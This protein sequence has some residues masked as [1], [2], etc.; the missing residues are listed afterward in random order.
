MNAISFALKL[1]TFDIS[2]EILRL[3]FSKAFGRYHRGMVDVEANIEALVI[4][5]YV[6]VVCNLIGGRDVTIPLIR[7]PREEVTP[8]E[9]VYRIPKH[10]TDG[11]SI[12]MLKHIVTADVFHPGVDTGNF[13]CGRSGLALEV[14]N[15]MNAQ[16][17][18][19]D[20][21]TTKLQLIGD[22]VV[23][24]RRQTLMSDYSHLM[25]VVEYDRNMSDI[26]PRVIPVF[27]EMCLLATKA[28][29]YTQM[30]V[31]I[32]QGVLQG[33]RELGVIADEVR[34]YADAHEMFRQQMKEIYQKSLFFNDEVKT[35][36]HVNLLM[37]GMA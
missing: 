22:N 4:R 27:S 15:V 10:L 20:V 13:Q 16:A 32:D 29:I 12:I 23:H 31:A 30:N 26:Q 25:A 28:Y 36:R 3:A 6:M 7:V 2:P 1:I 17:A 9:T 33:G 21:G 8:Y 11:R 5:G 34:K 37:R 18:I 24:V 35:E 19:P 14:N